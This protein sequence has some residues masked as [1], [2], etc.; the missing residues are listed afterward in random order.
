MSRKLNRQMA[1]AMAELTLQDY[2]NWVKPVSHENTA[3]LKWIY[4]GHGVFENP[5][6]LTYEPSRPMDFVSAVRCMEAMDQAGLH[7]WTE[8]KY[9][10]HMSHS[11]FP[12]L[13]EDEYDS[14]IYG[15]F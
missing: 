12:P 13:Y 9:A 5:W 3:L 6:G 8:T 15:G 10:E 11:E 2:L 4:N 14:D 1:S 7:D